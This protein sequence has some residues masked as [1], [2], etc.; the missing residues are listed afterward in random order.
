MQAHPLFK[1][2]R[3]DLLKDETLMRVVGQVLLGCVRKSPG[4]LVC[5]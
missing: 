2:L 5:A 4:E 3:V 1:K